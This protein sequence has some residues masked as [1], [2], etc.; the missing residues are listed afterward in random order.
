MSKRYYVY[1]HRKIGNNEIFY[2]GKGTLNRK[3]ISSGRSK[4]WLKCSS[5]SGWYSE[6]YKSDLTF[7]EAE[8]LE[9]TLIDIHR[10]T[11]CNVRRKFTKTIFTYE[12]I[13]KVFEIEKDSES[14]ISRING[15][16]KC[17]WKEVNGYLVEYQGRSIGVHRIVYML[18]NM[19][20]N[21]DHPVDHIDGNKYNNIP[22]N[23]R[24]VPISVNN[25]N[26]VMAE[27]PLVSR[28][29]QSGEKGGKGWVLT[30]KE[31]SKRVK[32]YFADSKYGGK[33]NSKLACIKFKY[34]NKD[35]LMSLG[36]TERMFPCEPTR[37]QVNLY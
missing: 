20:L 9:T 12:E 31:E 6:I 21:F 23:L 27:E 2:V 5:E 4:Q 28:V 18:H 33:D 19:Q 15:K 35:Y 24:N 3:D 29:E 13:S 7:T 22:E 1:F 17:G 10:D 34:E 11:I 8:E 14:G 16:G 37:D 25:M 36:Y 32:K 30:Y 26:R